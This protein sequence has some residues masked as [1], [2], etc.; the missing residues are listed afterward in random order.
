MARGG[1]LHWLACWNAA[2]CVL[3]PDAA[4]LSRLPPPR[5]KAR[6]VALL[7]C[8]PGSP[9]HLPNL[10]DV[11]TARGRGLH[12]VS[13]A[14]RASRR[15]CLCRRLC[16]RDALLC[17]YQQGGPV[18]AKLLLGQLGVVQLLVQL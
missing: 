6:L 5:S 10:D 13:A 4:W 17:V 1:A 15:L 11:E 14:G 12:P 3:T 18:G 9:A 7:L 8:T 16:R 2:C